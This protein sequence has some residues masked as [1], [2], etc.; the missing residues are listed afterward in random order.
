MVLWRLGNIASIW[1]HPHQPGRKKK[2]KKKRKKKKGSKFSF[3][4]ANN[5]TWI[6][7]FH[8]K[9]V[10]NKKESFNEGGFLS[11]KGNKE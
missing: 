4:Q 1:I 9:R 8:G 3:K 6:I 7:V 5:N 10:G 2:K 11:V